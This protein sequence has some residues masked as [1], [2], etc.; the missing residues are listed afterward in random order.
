MQLLAVLLLA[1]LDIKFKASGYFYAGTAKP[2]V[3][4][5]RGQLALVALQFAGPVVMGKARGFLN[6]SASHGLSSS[7]PPS[8]LRSRA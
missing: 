5:R 1:A 7:L 6:F 2:G 3:V 8:R 4:G